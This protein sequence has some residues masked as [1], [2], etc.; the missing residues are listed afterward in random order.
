MR[1]HGFMPSQRADIA[2]DPGEVHAC[3]AEA[4]TAV[5]STIGPDGVPDPLPMWFVVDDDVIWMRTYAKSQKARNLQRDPRAALLIEA[6]DRY[7]ELRGVQLTGTMEIDTDVDRICRIFAAL[8]V[9]YEGLDPQF[10]DDTMTAYRPTATKQV[11][12]ACRWTDPSWRIVSWDH[13]KQT[14]I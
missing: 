3:I 12:L 7:A 14:G 13:R 11:A 9:K 4:R 2:M 10:V 1:D 5:L 6:G 8:M